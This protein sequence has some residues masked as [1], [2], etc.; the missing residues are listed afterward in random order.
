MAQPRTQFVCQK[1]GASSAKWLGR[2]AACG[3]WASLVEETVRSASSGRAARAPAATAA[4]PLSA[5]PSGVAGRKSTGI[6]ELDRVLGGGLVDG[7]LVLVGGDPGIGKSTLL[8]QAAAGIARGTG[9][10]VLY[11]SAE[12]SVSQ[13]A[14]RARRLGVADERVLVLA[15]TSLESALAAIETDRPGVAI[16]DSVQTV[17]SASLDSAAGSVAQIR[18]VASRCQDL[19]KSRGVAVLLVGHVTKDGALAGP[20]VLEHIVDTVLYFEGERGHPFRVLRAVKNRFGSASEVGVFDMAREGLREVSDPSSLLLAERPRDASGS[21]VVASAEGSRP[22]LVEV[23]ALVASSGLGTPRRAATGFDVSRVVVLLAVLERSAQVSTLSHD[24]F[25][26]VAGG[27]R[28][29]ERAA[30]LGVVVAVASS[31]RG[32]PALPRAVVF[33]EVGLSGELRAVSRVESRIAEAR[34][35]GYDLVVLP[36]ANL[37]SL[38]EEEKTGLTLCGCATIEQAIDCALDPA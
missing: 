31:A 4:V 9:S 7:S 30:D 27:A 28:I 35:L 8:L 13:T 6:G 18:E 16:I 12:E 21:V 14:L 19:A 15:E 11:V 23:Q 29:D 38:S 24:V 5:V 36:R 34:R 22:M 32:R 17:F 10:K 25:V 3:E 1:C 37:A 20:K 2:C 33:G 26:N